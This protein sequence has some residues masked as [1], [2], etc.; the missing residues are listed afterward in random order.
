MKKIVALFLLISALLL[1]GCDTT[2]TEIVMPHDSSYYYDE[3]D[4]TL[5]ELVKHFEDLG[6]TDIKTTAS[7]YSGYARNKIDFVSAKGY[8]TGFKEGDTL[9]SYDTIEI[10]YYDKCNNLTVDNC[11]DLAIALST[12]ENDVHLQFAEK[13]DGQFIEFDGCITDSTTYMA[14][15]EIIINVAGG[16][17]EQLG[18]N[19][20]SIHLDDNNLFSDSPDTSVNTSLPVGENVRIIGEVDSYYSEYYNHLSIT[21][22]YLQSRN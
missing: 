6:F 22:V 15:T 5:D 19:T 8:W 17:Y 9:Y 16:D 7:S 11:P 4:G 14:G 13:Y 10:H 18:D 2:Y 21:V 1:S 3:Y 12:G 20:L